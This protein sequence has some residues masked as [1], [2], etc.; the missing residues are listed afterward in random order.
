MYFFFTDVVIFPS[1]HFSRFDLLVFVCTCSVAAESFTC[2]CHVFLRSSVYKGCFL[3][4]LFKVWVCVCVY[5]TNPLMCMSGQCY[6]IPLFVCKGK[7]L[8]NNVMTNCS[9]KGISSDDVR[10]L[11]RG[12]H[13]LFL[14]PPTTTTTVP[15]TPLSLSPQ[16]NNIITLQ[17]ILLLHSS[18]YLTGLKIRIN[19]PN[20]PCFL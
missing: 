9:G 14:S 19:K 20:A 4:L 7:C 16:I 10:K 5:T 2:C 15:P 11:C 13:S 12:T 18:N 1:P 3:W 17:V 6:P 8:V